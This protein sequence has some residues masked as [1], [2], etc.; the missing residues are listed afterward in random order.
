MK[1]YKCD[2]HPGDKHSWGLHKEAT[3]HPSFHSEVPA[4]FPKQTWPDR[5][6]PGE[7]LPCHLSLGAM[8]Q[9]DQQ[10]VWALVGTHP[11]S[12]QHWCC[13]G[14]INPWSHPASPARSLY[15]VPWHFQGLYFRL[16]EPSVQQHTVIYG[17]IESQHSRFNLILLK[18]LVS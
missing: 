10:S 17:V 9:R 16:W 11:S 4:L 6:V 13:K 8:W 3:I 1:R 2:S 18:P 5:V 12:Q 14:F 7:F 15:Y